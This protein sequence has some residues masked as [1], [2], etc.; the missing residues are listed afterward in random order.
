MLLS[1]RAAIGG[2]H[3]VKSVGGC[4]SDIHYM[5]SYIRLR[6]WCNDRTFRQGQDEVNNG[7]ENRVQMYGR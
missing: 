1:E 4:N 2:V 6:G 5:L 7:N 3:I